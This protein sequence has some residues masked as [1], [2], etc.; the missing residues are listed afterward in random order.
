MLGPL[1]TTALIFGGCCTNVFALEG[2][3]KLES[4]SGL[5][6]TFLQFVFTALSSY[7]TQ[8]E[9]GAPYTLRRTK[10]PASRWAFIAFMFFAIN[11]LN[12][13]AFAYN[14]S[15]PVHIILRSFGSVTTML[16]GFIRGKRYSPLQILS[17]VLLTVGVLVS[18]WADSESKGKSMSVESSASTSDFTT[19]LAILLLAQVFSAYMGAYTE[20]TYSEFNASWTEN[21]FYSHL[22]SLPFYL[23]FAAT[24][25][26][27]YRTLS[28][29]PPLELEPLCAFAESMPQ[30][31]LFLFINAVTQLACISGVNLLSAKSSAVTVTIVLNIRKLVSFILST[32]L[33]G[34]HLNSKMILGS[35]MVFGSG[36]L[37]GWE[38]S[39]RLPRK[40]SKAK[41]SETQSVSREQK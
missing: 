26:K 17:V 39:W 41:K 40:N 14:I 8:F 15:I 30:G 11:M 3:L 1:T 37:Y 27:Q 32:L 19:G 25:R 29:T 10:V 22:F 4:S 16:A 34:H 35:T 33:F 13:W 2:I 20:D 12:N 31:T 28:K 6:I 7:P 23:P 24:L 5:I 9:P 38:T 36:A 21:L 18:A